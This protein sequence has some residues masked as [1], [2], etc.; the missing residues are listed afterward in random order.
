[1]KTKS[2]KLSE[3]LI[4]NSDEK[5]VF[6]IETEVIIKKILNMKVPLNPCNEKEAL[7]TMQLINKIYE[8]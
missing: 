7:R 6:L 2:Q 4:S 1:M 8:K 3:K 5:K